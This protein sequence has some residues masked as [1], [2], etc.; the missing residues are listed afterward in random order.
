M[1]HAGVWIWQFFFFFF[2]LKF[3]NSEAS[4]LNY[5]ESVGVKQENQKFVCQEEE[6]HAGR[7]KVV[8]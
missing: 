3:D 2:N 1:D 7:I 6:I 4:S 8:R 5:L